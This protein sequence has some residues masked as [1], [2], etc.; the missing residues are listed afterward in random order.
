MWLDPETSG[1]AF[2]HMDTIIHQVYMDLGMDIED[3]SITD[4]MTRLVSTGFIW[5]FSPRGSMYTC[6]EPGIP[7]LMNHVVNESLK[8]DVDEEL[9][10]KPSSR[11]R[12][13]SPKG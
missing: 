11:S 8:A 5:H 12:G 7:S 9:T 1:R 3:S 4:T 10:G 2:I 13:P 6:Y